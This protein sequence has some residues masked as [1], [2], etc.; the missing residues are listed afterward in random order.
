MH[1]LSTLFTLALLPAALAMPTPPKAEAV[2][3]TGLAAAPDLANLEQHIAAAAAKLVKLS[4][5]Q[6]EELAASRKAKRSGYSVPLDGTVYPTGTISIGTPAQA[7]SVLFD[8]GSADLVVPVNTDASSTGEVFNTKSSSTFKN[9]GKEVYAQYLSGDFNGTI[10]SDTVSLGGV[11]IPSQKLLASTSSNKDAPATAILGLNFNG[12]SALQGEK[13]FMTNAV[14]NKALPANLFSLYLDHEGNNAQLILG[15]TD[16]S[17]YT[18]SLT[19]VLTYKDAKLPFWAV[20]GLGLSVNG[21]GVNRA[22][23]IVLIDSGSPV[24]LVSHKIAEDL[25]AKIPGSQLAFTQD[26]GPLGTVS[27]YAFPCATPASV[28][29]NLRGADGKTYTFDMNPADF[30]YAP[31]S[32]DTCVGTFGG[33]D[34]PLSRTDGVSRNGTLLGSPFLRSFYSVFSYGTDGNT[35]SVSFATAA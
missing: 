32:E 21:Q 34:Y 29:I 4:E 30:I 23:N 22:E 28:G 9:T 15:G 3:I 25:Y 17:L 12:V 7:I 33:V 16:S 35:P 20:D 31:L 8:T 18:G 5:I 2:R 6:P 11:S 1:T 19:P 13:N 26:F 10:V 24:N 14:A 27:F